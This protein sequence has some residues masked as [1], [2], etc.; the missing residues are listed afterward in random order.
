MLLSSPAVAPTATTTE[1]TRTPSQQRGSIDGTESLTPTTTTEDPARNKEST[2]INATNT[3]QTNAVPMMSELEMDVLARAYNSR[4]SPIHKYLDLAV[5]DF[6]EEGFALL[7]QDANIL[8]PRLMGPNFMNERVRFR[9]PAGPAAGGGG[10]GLG[11]VGLGAGLDELLAM[12]LDLGHGDRRAVAMRGMGDGV[13]GRRQQQG[14][15]RRGNLDPRAPLL[16]LFWQSLLPWNVFPTLSR[17]VPRPPP[18][19]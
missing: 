2:D 15:P 12:A 5:S 9:L 8:D 11:G 19:L 13:G 16:Q 4:S 1:H 7:P 10:G 3:D 14:G 18:W 6:V 17:P